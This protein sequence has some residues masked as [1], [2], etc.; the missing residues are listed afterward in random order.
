VL[1]IDDS[2]TVLELIS[3]AL[4]SRGYEVA[5]AKSGKEGLVKYQEFK[6]D[7]VTLDIAMPTMDG[8]ETFS[9]LKRLDNY[10]NVIMLTAANHSSALERCLREGAINFISKPFSTSDLA[11]AIR[12]AM[13]S[14]KYCS[15]DAAVF[16]SHLQ[17]KLRH[18]ARDSFFPD[19][20]IELKS[21]RTV[22]NLEVDEGRYGAAQVQQYTPSESDVCFIT[23]ITGEREGMVISTIGADDLQY[24]F[25]DRNHGEDKVP[26]KAMEFFNMINIKVASELANSTRSNIDGGAVMSFVRPGTARNFWS[27]AERLWNRIEGSVFEMNHTGKTVQLETHL[28]F[29]GRLFE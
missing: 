23:T 27:E 19:S 14:S 28:C 21:V 25:G 15:H 1:A 16:F 12:K 10:V 9:A 20:S 6:P 7:I 5:T 29:D 2:S 13:E 11:N 8:Y 18:V 17:S 26:D 24:L 22:R 4:S 3:T